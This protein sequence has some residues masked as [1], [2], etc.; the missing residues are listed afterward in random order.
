MLPGV[1]FGL[2][3]WINFASTRLA[4]CGDFVMKQNPETD[5]PRRLPVG[6]DSA[7]RMPGSLTR[8]IAQAWSV[9]EALR[10]WVRT[11]AE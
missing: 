2:G 3:R 6:A 4:R 10:C 1:L 5:C 7:T 11:V 8:C 9:A